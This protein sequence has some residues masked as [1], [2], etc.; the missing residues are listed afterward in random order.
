MP[1]VVLTKEDPRKA[2]IR[3][4]IAG[5]L[6]R[7]QINKQDLSKKTGINYSTLNAH[8]RNP[9]D[10]RMGEIWKILDVIKASDDERRKVI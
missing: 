8:L 5:G 1:K 4:V 2:E 10:M 6:A 7:H 3:S 9:E